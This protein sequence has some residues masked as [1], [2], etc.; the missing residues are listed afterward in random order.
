MALCDV[1]GGRIGARNS[2]VIALAACSLVWPLLRFVRLPGPLPIGRPLLS[3]R[4]AA[5]DDNPVLSRM[6]Y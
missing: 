4:A 1:G 3:M 6:L 2:I 5:E